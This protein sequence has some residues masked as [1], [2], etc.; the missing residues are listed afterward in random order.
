MPGRVLT[1]II[2]SDFLDRHP[3]R[4][5]DSYRSYFD[6]KPEEVLQQGAEADEEILEMLRALGY[7]N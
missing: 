6:R 7:I 4:R 5:I 3:I 2:E 1:E